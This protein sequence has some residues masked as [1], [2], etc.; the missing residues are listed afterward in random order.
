MAQS[1]YTPIVLYTSTSTGVTPSAGNLVTGEL[2]LN[3]ADGKLFYKNSG[4]NTVQVLANAS[5]STVA[6]STTQVIYNNSG[7]YAGSAN[8]TFNGTSLTLANDAS[9]SGLTVGKGGNSVAGN[10][11][12]G[13]AALAGSNSGYAQNSAFG[14]QAL[15]ANT[16]GYQNSAFGGTN[17]VFTT[18]GANNSAF[19]YGAFYANTTGSSNTAVGNYALNANTTASNNTAVGYQAGYTN[20]VGQYNVF[21]GWKAGYAH[22]GASGGNNTFV[23]QQAGTAVTT[24]YGNSFYGVASGSAI[25]TGYSNTIL[26]GYT[27]N[28]N[29]LDIRTASNYVVLS[30]GD[31]NVKANWNA[32]GV[33]SQNSSIL[34]LATVTAAAPNSTQTFD[35]S[36]QAVQYFT[37][38]AANNWTLNIRGNSST[39]LNSVMAVGQSLS[40]TTLTTQGST[41]YY[42]SAVQIDG[43]TSGVTT[44]WQG[45]A[46]TS[47][48]ASSIDCYTYVII[49]TAASTYTVLASQTKFA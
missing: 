39:T 45:S 8:M 32:T 29:G 10:T 24:G 43:T 2:G 15:N 36:T 17:S 33:M 4:T 1:G 25:T 14:Y 22:T 21:V 6:G 27:G 42:N 11:A 23:G 19:G 44:K 9:I 30:D 13:Q 26:G 16:T 41:A 20:T 3:A 12:V 28:Q 18:T 48:N 40:I 35:A 34:E 5:T 47:G 49:K 31:G 37:T 38:N 46:P 7:A